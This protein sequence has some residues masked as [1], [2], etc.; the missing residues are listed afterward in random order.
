MTAGSESEGQGSTVMAATLVRV[1]DFAVSNTGS[2]KTVRGRK[3]AGKETVR[4]DELG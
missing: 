4:V 2:G 1:L 3:A